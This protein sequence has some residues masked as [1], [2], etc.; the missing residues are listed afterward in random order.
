MRRVCALVLVLVMAGGL[1]G[2]EPENVAPKAKVTADS[3]YNNQYLVKFITD[4]KV[5]GALSKQ[6]PGKAWA[7]QGNTHRGGAE[8][9]FEWPKAV[10][11]GEVVYFGRTAWFLNECWKGCEIYIDDAD[12]PAVKFNLQAMHGPV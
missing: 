10:K 2:A 4:G 9:V 12:K 3:E 7:V 6:D 8:L 1:W 5:P 11:V